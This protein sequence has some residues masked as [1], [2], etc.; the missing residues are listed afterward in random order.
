MATQTSYVFLTQLEVGLVKDFLIFKF[1][2]QYLVIHQRSLC[3]RPPVGLLSRVSIL[4]LQ[5][6]DDECVL[7]KVDNK[8]LCSNPYKF[9]LGGLQS[10][11]RTGFRNSQIWLNQTSRNSICIDSYR[12]VQAAIN[13]GRRHKNL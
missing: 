9:C 7:D 12:N 1:V 13:G 6:G 5:E 10:L 8:K 11:Q 2:I 4:V 3:D